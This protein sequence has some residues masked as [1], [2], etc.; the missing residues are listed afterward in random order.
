MKN[1][2]IA[3]DHHY[4]TSSP[5]ILAIGDVIE[6]VMLAHKAEDEGIAAAEIIAGK[7]GH[8]NYEAIP[9]VVY[10]WPE[11][12]SVGMTE[13]QCKAKGI[14][15]RTGQFPFMANGRARSLGETDGFVKI[16]A[17]ARTDRLLGFH[18]VGPCAS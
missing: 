9:N 18:I 3:V 5:H 1:G 13:E 14:E 17:D 15:V 4:R 2:R 8:V 16:I 11:V 10:T 12:A 7:P 6:G